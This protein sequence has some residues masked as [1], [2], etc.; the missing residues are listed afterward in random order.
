MEIKTLLFEDMQYVLRYP[1]CYREGEKYPLLLFLHGAGTRGD[2]IGKVLGNS[3]LKHSAAQEGLSFITVAPL[4]HKNTWFDMLET[5]CRFA[6][7]LSCAP[8]TDAA[9]FYLTG[10]SMGGYGTWQLAMSCP[11]LF[12]AIV[13]V[14]GG[15]MYWNAA[16]LA[17]VPIWAFHGAKD[18][19]V[20]PEESE[21]MVN[22][23]N[24]RGG[25]AKLTVYPENG[26][27]S[28]TDTYTNR[29]VYEWLLSHTNQNAKQL[30]DEYNNSKAFG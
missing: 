22:A 21:K 1:E 12:A 15:G 25:S 18:G 19:T 14:C 10:N 16:R 17:N 13:P 26:H 29:A 23:V 6:K 24:K 8:F 28:W 4:C 2:D 30:A 20:F 27:D 5:L 7:M 11:E 3:F 9:R